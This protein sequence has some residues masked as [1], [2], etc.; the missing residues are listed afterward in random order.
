MAIAPGNPPSVLQPLR[1]RRRDTGI[2][3]PVQV[4]SHQGIEALRTADAANPGARIW[5]RPL[6]VLIPTEVA[7]DCGMISLTIPI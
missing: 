5:Q 1:E 4:R 6:S 3:R 2:R 7:R